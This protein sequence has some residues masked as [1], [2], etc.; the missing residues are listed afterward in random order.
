MRAKLCLWGT[1]LLALVAIP[2]IAHHSFDAEFDRSKPVTITGKVTKMEWMNPHVWVYLDVTGTDGKVVKWQCENGAPN[3]LKRSGWSRESIKDGDQITITGNL[4][5][6]GSNT[7]NANS[8]VLA[9]GKRVF[10]GSSRGDENGKA[11]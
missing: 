2:A 7:C 6:D 10:A 1:S 9:D 4:A 5:K 3:M 8:I 11:K